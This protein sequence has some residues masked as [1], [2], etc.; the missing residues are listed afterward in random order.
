M[1]PGNRRP[2]AL[3]VAAPAGTVFDFDLR[4][5]SAGPDFIPDTQRG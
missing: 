4:A 1:E 3:L 5:G 2:V